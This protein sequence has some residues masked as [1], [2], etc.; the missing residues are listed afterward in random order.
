MTMRNKS[1]PDLAREST[2]SLS[3]EFAERLSQDFPTLGDL[4]DYLQ[5][6][7]DFEE[8]GMPDALT[9]IK[10]ASLDGEERP[11][12]P[13]AIL[14]DLIRDCQA[15]LSRAETAL[16]RTEQGRPRLLL[17]TKNIPGFDN[18]THQLLDGREVSVIGWDG[19]NPIVSTAAKCG[20]KLDVGSYDVLEM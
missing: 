1:L 6:G 15:L 8:L 12:T 13:A 16:N 11:K 3:V 9:I 5:A 20:V 4:L 7:G 18:A 17:L 10:A 19:E 2:I 14:S